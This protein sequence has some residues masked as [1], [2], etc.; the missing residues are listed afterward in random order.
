MKKKKK[1]KKD[2]Y[3]FKKRMKLNNI[4]KNIINHLTRNSKAIYNTTIYYSKKILNK[5]ND[6]LLLYNNFIKKYKAPIDKLSQNGIC[7]Y[8]SKHYYNYKYMSNHISQQSIK[9]AYKAIQSFFELKKSGIQNAQF[10]KYLKKDSRYNVC[11]TKNIFKK[12]KCN[13]KYFIRLTLGKYIQN[14]FIHISKATK[15]ST[16]NNKKYYPKNK[17]VTKKQNKLYCKIGKKQYVNNK[18]IIKGM[19]MKC[20]IPK[21]I[22]EK[23]IIEIEIKPVLNGIHYELIVKYE[24]PLIKID[25]TIK[26]PIAIDLGLNNLL[27]IFGL[28]INPLIINGRILK[29]IN[30]Y[31]NKTLSKLK[32]KHAEILN[33]TQNKKSIKYIKLKQSRKIKR[34][35]NRRNNKINNEL[36]QISRYMINY[37]IAN[38]ID[39][40]IIGYIK[41]WKQKCNMGSKTNQNFVQ[42]P[43][44]NL[45]NKLKYK[46]YREGIQLLLQNESYTSKC[47]AL[48]NETVRRH[49]K[50]NGKRIK[51]GLFKS[52]YK[53]TLINADVNGAINIYRKTF[54]LMRKKGRKFNKT[55][56]KQRKKILQQVTKVTIKASSMR[57]L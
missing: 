37:C 39:T 13:N 53:K 3:V 35:F 25:K 28:K 10:P 26:N 17:I 36:H 49:K 2:I 32:R 4:N 57:N 34:L 46:S 47:D 18:Y 21:H 44:L 43:F 40:I 11:F 16:I 24:V 15:Y 52:G 30:Q 42:I 51:R 12:I 19:H 29:S 20:P 23:N 27:T 1:K 5:D 48:S 31:Y 54:D 38:K 50:Y 9:K 22:Y 33:K 14:N 8:L 56:I 41:G 7:M 6:F 55:L 45:I